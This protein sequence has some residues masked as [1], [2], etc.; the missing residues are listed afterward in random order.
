[1]PV[2]EKAGVMSI[3]HRYLSTRSGT[4]HEGGAAVVDEAALV[5]EADK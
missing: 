5:D 2:V 4:S 3:G 1:M